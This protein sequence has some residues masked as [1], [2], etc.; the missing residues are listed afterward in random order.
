MRIRMHAALLA[1]A[2]TALAGVA[3]AYNKPNPPACPKAS[4]GDQ[5]RLPTDNEN[6]RLQ[7]AIDAIKNAAVPGSKL[8]TIAKCLDDKLKACEICV[9]GFNT[10][11]SFTDPNG[12]ATWSGDPIVL[13]WQTVRNAVNNPPSPPGSVNGSL[14]DLAATL[15]HEGTH[16]V[17]D[18]PLP[19]NRKQA[20]EYEKEAT[21]N[22]KAVRAAWGET[23]ANS[24]TY[25]FLCDWLTELCARA[26]ADPTS[27]DKIYDCPRAGFVM[28]DISR[29]P[30]PAVFGAV[31]T[32]NYTIYVMTNRSDGSSRTVSTD[33]RHVTGL[34]CYRNAPSVGQDTLWVVG[35]N[36][37]H[38]VTQ[39]QKIVFDAYAAVVSTSTLQTIP[40]CR[41]E[42]PTNIP[43]STKTYV[44]DVDSHKVRTYVD[45][46]ADGVPDTWGTDFATSSSFPFLVDMKS[47]SVTGNG[48]V[49]V[50]LW[51]L[52]GDL[53]HIDLET[54]HLIDSNADGVA[55]TYNVGKYKDRTEIGPHFGTYPTPGSTSVVAFGTPNH[56]MQL[57][58]CTSTGDPLTQ[59]GSVTTAYSDCEGTITF[60]PGLTSGD[61]VM[62][63]DVTASRQTGPFEVKNP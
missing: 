58:T 28:A 20:K 42:S 40:H 1:L 49:V 57:W 36:A 13:Y 18:K 10:K 43:G 61:F 24:A 19:T 17:N 56:S 9:G 52:N 4:N 60:A 16:A 51:D 44:L 34:C 41:L 48:E 22:D 35:Q 21:E 38:A 7:Q 11:N 50:S 23:A 33:V 3:M 46:D 27:I 26:D 45:T 62:L 6:A 8:E 12:R 31:E 55:D 2:A 30:D 37:S 5:S 47:L 54:Y 14:C 25:K 39:C 15:A 53:M 29:T 63:K 59:L 32:M